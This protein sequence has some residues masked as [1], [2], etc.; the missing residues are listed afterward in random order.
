[1]ILHELFFTIILFAQVVLR[2]CLIIFRFV[3]FFVWAFCCCFLFQQ[4]FLLN[5]PRLFVIIWF[6]ISAVWLWLLVSVCSFVW[7]FANEWFSSWKNA[8]FETTKTNRNTAT[9]NR[10]VSCT[11]K[12]RAFANYILVLKG[13]FIALLFMHMQKKTTTFFSVQI[14]TWKFT[15]FFFRF[16]YSFIKFGFLL[17]KLW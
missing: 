4:T 16:C 10:S 3:R 15:I 11:H 5:A 2:Y 14:P 8:T 17:W 6:S 13:F 1:M 12:W 9:K 7:S